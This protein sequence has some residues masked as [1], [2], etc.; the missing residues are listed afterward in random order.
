MEEKD[1][2]FFLVLAKM[3][4]TYVQKH[5]NSDPLITQSEIEFNW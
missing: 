2:S 1:G 5:V 3:C 4:L